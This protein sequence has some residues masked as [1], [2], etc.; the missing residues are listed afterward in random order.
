MSL[1]SPIYRILIPVRRDAASSS[2]VKGRLL[3]NLVRDYLKRIGCEVVERFRDAGTE[4][5][6]LCR[7]T[8]TGHKIVVEC[9]AHQAN[10]GA[11]VIN[12]IFADVDEFDAESGIIFTISPLGSEARTRMEKMNAKRKREFLRVYLPN[13]VVFLLLQCEALIAPSFPTDRPISLERYL[14]L[15]EGRRVWVACVLNAAREAPE[16]YL[17]W[18]GETGA[19]IEPN[20]APTIADTDFPH[21]DIGWLQHASNQR[22][23]VSAA[24]PLTE[25]I[26]GDEWRDY[27]PSRPDDFVGR[28]GIISDIANYFELV[29]SRTTKTRLIGIKGRSGWGKSSL[30][31]KIAKE[32]EDRSVFVS[33]LDC[34]SAALSSYPDLALYKALTS[35]CEKL[36][37]GGLFAPRFE[38]R[39]NPF[40]DENV[41][42]FLQDVQRRKAVICLIFDQFEAIIHREDLGSLF[43]RMRELA[44][45]ADEFGGSIVFGFSWKTDGMIISDNPGYHMWHSL[46]D[47][48]RD[49]EVDK[50]T[51]EDADAFIN[52]ALRSAGKSLPSP[53]LRFIREQYAGYPWL[54]K[55][56]IRHCVDAL[57][58]TETE[59]DV[60]SFFRVTE[61]FDADIQELSSSDNA[62]LRFIARE[63]PVEQHIASEQCGSAA[64]EH[65]I[66]RRLVVQSGNKLSPYWDVF[67]DYLISGQIPRIPNTYIPTLSVR[68]IR[69]VLRF[70]VGRK[71]SSYLKLS[72]QLG[73]SMGTTDNM[74]RD[75][76]NMGLIIPDRPNQK[77]EIVCR[78]PSDATKCIVDYLQSHSIFLN[79]KKHIESGKKVNL[80]RLVELA[81]SD[82]EF[83]SIDEST[84]RVYV[85]KIATYCLD[86]GLF[87]RERLSFALH[88]PVEN[89]LEVDV[90]RQS[91]NSSDI[92]L[93]AASPARV[94]DLLMYMRNGKI[95]NR[96]DADK[97]DL[98]NAI[99]ASSSLG[100]IEHKNG[101]VR[102]L[103]EFEREEEVKIAVV[104][105]ARRVEP[106]PTTIERADFDQL[107]ALDF[108]VQIAD[109]FEKNWAPNSCKRYGFALRE[110]YVWLRAEYLQ[111][112]DENPSG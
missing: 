51:R 104:E 43:S 65:L 30:A 58:N 55:K 6:L 84:L 80:D 66:N 96:W 2:Q 109:I 50:F 29:K 69:S 17:A 24:Q 38:H 28:S 87:R 67:R 20:S 13:D 111:R 4:I 63:A 39:A 101:H 94:I 74:V 1:A 46:A 59:R 60:N 62:A 18:D 108:G 48:R 41:K 34:R 31:L 71:K 26:A 15:F 16:G 91:L 88:T 53:V 90:G 32:L 92:F 47:R 12:K 79:A 64:I 99:F 68:K 106:F 23:E 8:A 21:A 78:S 33:V 22:R 82:F 54:L 86:F 36:Y 89:I 35:G 95:K 7:Q 73:M 27:R 10:L 81:R 76:S 98:R 75:L 25:V 57:S 37:S 83:I 49:F 14:C 103:I 112:N 11:E 72:G 19:P 56:L 85:R 3:E 77:F 52:L 70:M 105:A 107:D 9:K 97:Y 61:L 93:G 5:D 102:L 100:L 42:T 40:E 45:F 44:F 110:W